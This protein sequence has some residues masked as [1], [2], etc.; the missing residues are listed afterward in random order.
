M[1]TVVARPDGECA[2]GDGR[3]CIGM[4]RVVARVQCKGTACDVNGRLKSCFLR[5]V[6]GSLQALAAVGVGKCV[7]PHAVALPGL[8]IKGAAVDV[9]RG[10][11]LNSVSVNV[12]IKGAAVDGNRTC[13]LGVNHG[14]LGFVRRVGRALNAVVGGFDNIGSLIKNDTAVAGNA[15]VDRRAGSGCAVIL[16]VAADVNRAALVKDEG[17]GC[18]ALDAVLRVGDDIQ[19]TVAA[20]GNNRAAFHLDRRAFKRFGN[21]NVCGCF[22]CR[23]LVIGE[24]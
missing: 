10:V 7:V 22:I 1:H 2:A 9:Q 13:G 15:V 24:C 19:I 4:Y 16:R 3:V 12:N 17:S 14:S 8:D 11:R 18:A 23:I 5:P 21:G 6:A 20:E